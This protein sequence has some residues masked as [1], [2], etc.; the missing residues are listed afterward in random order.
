MPTGKSYKRILD[1][2]LHDLIAQGNHEAYLKL[3]RR[4][5]RY[6]EILATETLDKCSALGVTYSEIMTVCSDNFLY[7]VKKYDHQ[8]CSFYTFWQNTIE[9]FVMDYITTTYCSETAKTFRSCFSFDEENSERRFVTEMLLETDEE[10]LN[11]AKI[12]DVKAV[13]EKNKDAFRHEE[14]AMLLLVL[15]GYSLAD[16]E[17]S[18]IMSMSAVYLTFNSACVKLKKMFD[19]H[20]K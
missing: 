11:E 20:K 16:F 4:Y 9:R 2:H 13:I 8:R 18:G 14:Y 19:Y 5:K 15:Q 7:V 6:A 10:Q 1:E 3:S 12:R 17:H